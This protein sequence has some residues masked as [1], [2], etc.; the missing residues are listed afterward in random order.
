MLGERI[1]H[2]IYLA[3]VFLL[4]IGLSTSEFMMSVSS[5]ALACNWL[6]EGKL[7]E[8][9]DRLKKNRTALVLTSMFFMYVVWMIGTS[10]LQEG[11][12]ELRI[13]L[14][15]LLFPVVLGSIPRFS[16]KEQVWVA[17]IFI[18]ATLCS[19]LISLGVYFELI[20]TKSDISDV[21]NISI[22][23]SHI[24]L[25]LL[26]CVAITIGFYFMV[27]RRE[28]RWIY[29]FCILW[30]IGFLYLIQSATGFVILFMLI[31][32]FGLYLWKKIQRQFLKYTFFALSVLIM[33]GG[34]LYIVK[35]HRA[36]FSVNEHSCNEPMANTEF[37]DRY[38]HDLENTQLENNNYI[39]RNIHWDGMQKAWNE[40]S[41]MD[42]FGKDGKG[43]QLDATLIRYLTSMGSC[44]DREGVEALSDVDIKA[45]ESGTPSCVKP[46]KGIKKRLNEIF[47]EFNA[48]DN[49]AN[50]SGNSV[51]MRLEF[52][53]TAKEV[54]RNNPWFG[55]GTGDGKNEMQQMY[56]QTN[57]VLDEDWRLGSH[58]EFL[59]TW[60]KT[61]LFGFLIFVFALF[62]P[63][64]KRKNWNILYLAFFLIA[65]LSFL[66]ENTLETQPGVTF[67]GFFNCWLLFQCFHPKED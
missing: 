12:K 11:M 41:A 62:Y 29:L 56:D 36:Y 59:S 5:I 13:R 54:I 58:N 6:L 35:A 61:G 64:G 66:A 31:G 32:L 67:F 4:V 27:E 50:P 38:Y 18:A 57:S 14:P 17:R 8:K 55:V 39:W 1:H 24:R 34:I 19:T 2:I 40:R 33:I 60:V 44:K 20:P 46:Q 49:G 48:Y 30:F 3:S 25:S 26:I 10:D 23:I 42:I 9:F 28:H 43:Q 51:V 63:L 16:V 47:W 7:K 45:I 15:L 53:K 21:R 65:G 52:W 22:F 37:G